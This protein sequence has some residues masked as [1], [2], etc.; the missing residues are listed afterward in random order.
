MA[1]ELGEVS[2]AMQ[3][4][5]SKKLHDIAKEAHEE[6]NLN[7]F[8]III[9]HKEDKMLCNV[10]REGIIVTSKNPKH[11]LLNSMCF[12]VVWDRG[13]IDPV[14]ILPRDIPLDD[15]LLVL[16]SHD[17]QIFKQAASLGAGAF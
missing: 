7:E 6:K 9:T 1:Y 16:G 4:D 3:N 8:W 13:L 12:H 2:G 10:I 5:L 11:P 17:E 14:W 15:D